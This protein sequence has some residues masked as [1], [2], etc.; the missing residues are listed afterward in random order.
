MLESW[1]SLYGNILWLFVPMVFY[2][3]RHSQIA[4]YHW[5]EE[6]K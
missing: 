6:W 4:L 3:Q 5:E 2:I 1:L